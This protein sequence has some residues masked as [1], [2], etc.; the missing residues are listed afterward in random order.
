MA[1]AQLMPTWFVSFALCMRLACI[2][3]A[4]K[5]QL[6]NPVVLP[7]PGAHS[8]LYVFGGMSADGQLLNDL[9]VFD[10]DF[11]QWSQ[12]TCY[13]QLPSPRKGL[14]I[15]L[16]LCSGILHASWPCRKRRQCPLPPTPTLQQ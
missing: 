15:A 16:Q 10:Q 13:G 1:S 12:V 6:K 9:W 8:Q 2:L 3:L 11:A 4:A 7:P 14:C 5:L